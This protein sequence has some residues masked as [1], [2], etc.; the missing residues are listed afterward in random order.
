MPF[1]FLAIIGA[2]TAVLG[3]GKGIK[4]AFDAKNAKRANS[5]AEDLISEAKIVIE[6]AREANSISL[7][8]LGSKKIFV[9]SATV[10]R[11]VRAFQKIK[12]FD[13]D[14][15]PGL[16]ELG[17]FK[18]NKQSF[19]ELREL[20]NYATSIA[21][22]VVT[23]ALGGAVA[24]FA[25]WG[26]ASLFAS[27]STTTAIATLSGA[28]A[29]N[30]TLAFFGG[31]SLAAGGLGMA[32][33]AAIL[34]GLVAGPALAVMGFIIGAKASANLDR[35]YSNFAEAERISEEL[36]AA[37]DACNAI[38]RRTYLF[39]RLLIRFN[40]IFSPLVYEFEIIIKKYGRD[41]SK[42]PIEVKHTIAGA[43]SIAGSVKAVLDTP[44]L[45]TDG[46]LTKKSKLI[47]SSIQEQIAGP[48]D[49]TI[50]KNI[51]EADEEE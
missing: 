6:Q 21:G 43:Y 32:G 5:D 8:V 27:A 12:N 15:S 49:V 16:E 24:G 35:A 31:G 41:Y 48:K 20:S 38:R 36:N 33:G 17:K 18:L 19:K 28:A 46:K 50:E 7:G 34:G 13:M 14:N 29:T 42:Y 40:A 4:A 37:A 44:I 9:L 11:F 25:A 30:A 2:G 45:T 26:G 3:I 1:P 22:G 39:T 23:G 10:G 47:A 51:S